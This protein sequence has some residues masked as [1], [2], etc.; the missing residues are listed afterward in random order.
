MIVDSHTHAWAAPSEDHPWVNGPLLDV[1]DEF[2]VHT[3]YTAERL[4]DDMDRNGVD[5]AVIVGYPI[6]DWRDNRYTVEAAREHDRLYG[7][8][9]VDQFADDAADRLREYMAVDGVLGFRLGAACPYDEMWKRFDPNVDWLRRA[10]GE[11]EFWEAARETDATVQIL[12]D[13]SQLDQALE[14]VERYPDLTYLFDHFS[15]AG[16]QTPIEDGTFARYAELA[17]YDSVAVKVSEIPHMSE[18]AFPYA[19]MHDHVRWF[20]DTFG[21]ERVVW[22]SD[23]PNVSDAAGYGD[24]RHWLDRVEGISETDREWITGRAFREHVL[25]G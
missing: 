14:L 9:M 5:E 6:C 13:H 24:A 4:L 8:V 12:C 1:V 17:E 11:A 16:P 10:I 3:V 20:V 21:R 7:I 2:D 15:H 23:Y 22:G 19:D 18:E 25:S